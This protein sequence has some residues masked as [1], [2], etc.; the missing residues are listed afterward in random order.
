MKKHRLLALLLALV[1]SF[2]SAITV[3][4]V[5]Y[6]EVEESIRFINEHKDMLDYY[7]SLR[8]EALSAKFEQAKTSSVAS[9]QEVQLLAEEIS[10]LKTNIEN[11]LGGNHYYLIALPDCLGPLPCTSLGVCDYCGHAE[12]VLTGNG[13]RQL[14][15]DTDGDDICNNCDRLMPYINCNHFC[16]SKN[17]IIQ[18][19]LLPI[20]KLF[21]SF[22]D[23]EEFCQC[24]A[25]HRA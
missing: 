24:G 4:A 9:E 10:T 21:W 8:F 18:K 20:M 25:Y 2:L 12:T 6:T 23:I 22:L 7:Y 13:Y 17:I 15:S 1:L 3:F 14:H 11:C 5:E 19:M 16:H